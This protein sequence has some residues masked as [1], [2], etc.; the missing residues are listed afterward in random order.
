MPSHTYC[1]FLIDAQGGLCVQ[2][3]LQAIWPS[4]ANF[5][6]SL[7]ASA[8]VTSSQLLCFFIFYIVQLPMLW[9][10]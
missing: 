1:F 7:P 3:M 6:N 4:F 10:P 5:P 2:V 8:N 9:I